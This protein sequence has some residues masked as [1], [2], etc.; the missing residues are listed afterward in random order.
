MNNQQI[1]VRQ[2]RHKWEV[3]MIIICLI[4][5]LIVVFLAL[6]PGVLPDSWGAAALLVPITPISIFIITIRLQYYSFISDGVEINEGIFPEV[7]YMY[8]DL[9]R[10]MGFGEGK[11][12]TSSIPRLY[13][14][15]G[16]GQMNAFA[17]KYRLSKGYI[18]VYSDLF[19]I[20]YHNNDMAG[21]KFIL[22]HELGHIK[23]GHVNVWRTLLQ[24]VSDLLLIGAS[25]TRAQ[26]WTADRCAYYYAPEGRTSLLSL[27][28]GKKFYQHVNLNAYVH[29]M[30]THKRGFWFRL[31]N[32]LSNHPIGHRRMEAMLETF[33]KGWAVHGKM[34]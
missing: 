26:E 34:L 19:E 28:A 33:E 10:T 17:S 24:P 3:P 16:N 5:T 27:Y 12:P 25:L 4:A 22:A 31:A 23:C 11:G 9:A 18:C 30:R 29:S 1:S 2:L 21:L 8:I 14:L 13:L 7:Y 20:A 15:N 6:L 32:F